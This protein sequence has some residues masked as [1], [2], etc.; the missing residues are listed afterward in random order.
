MDI[1]KALALLADRNGSELFLTVGYPPCMKI[2]GQHLPAGKT[3]LS[4]E[5]VYHIFDQLMGDD[6]FQE[7]RATCESNFAIQHPEA[8]RF[9]ISAFF[10]KG[11]P[12]MVV[13]RINH[14]IPDPQ[15]LGL[16]DVF[17][18]LILQERG[19]IL[20]TGPAGAGKTTT[21]ASLV[22]HRNT[23]GKGHIITIEDPIEFIHSHNN[24][25]VTQR[26]VGLDTQTYEE[27]LSNALRQA[28][29]LVVIGEIRSPRVMK[30]TIEFVQTGHLCIA[31]LHANTA[32]QA[33]ERIIH[34]FPQEQHEETLMDL[35]LSLQGIL[36][37]QLI[38][39]DDGTT[40]YPSHEILLNTP[41]LAEL[42]KKGKVDE[43]SGLMERSKD[44]GMQTIDQ[45][46]FNLFKAGKITARQAIQHADSSN[47]MR[48]LI[49]MDG[50]Q[51]RSSGSDFGH[52]SINP[53]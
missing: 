50:H 8:G 33:L 17:C 26:E 42:I 40:A 48:L 45:S 51:D 34:F 14:H 52:L 2:N 44:S 53:D 29:D 19:L 11:E 49:K 35:S 38:G 36:G 43:I 7:F 46:I 6:R 12:G 21:M 27:G 41:A 25:I 18:D 22:N 47:N 28:P 24:C 3:P 37:Q 13:R 1:N 30:H 31:T 32:Y 16:P 39:S 4:S 10:Q 5:Q 15:E 20:I 23:M 9:R